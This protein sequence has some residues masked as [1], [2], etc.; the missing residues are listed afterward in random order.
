VLSSVLHEV[1]S[2]AGFSLDAVQCA[3]RCAWNALR[4][5]GRLIVRDFARPAAA[6]RSV[7]LMHR[8][9]DIVAGHDF[10][11]FAG[12]CRWPVAL[13]A[14]TEGRH[15]IGYATDLASAYDYLLRK[16]FHDLWQHQLAER[17][18]FWTRATAEATIRRTGYRIIHSSEWRSG[19]VTRRRLDGKVSMRCRRT[20]EPIAPSHQLLIVAVKETG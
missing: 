6:S 20:G 17:Y 14:V 13:D 1:Y 11:A 16:D 18:G 19:W 12:A 15:W 4:S 7:T 5:G 3:L 10:A 8:R 9:T 2:S